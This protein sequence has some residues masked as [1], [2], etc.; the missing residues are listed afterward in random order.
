MTLL[1]PV[2]EAFEAASTAT[3]QTARLVLRPPALEDAPALA[4]LTNDRRIAEMTTRVPYPYT[5]ADAEEF[6]A[7][8]HLDR[9]RVFLITARDGTM[10][11]VCSIACRT[12]T[13]PEIGYWLGVP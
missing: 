9:E 4:R 3:L 2:A 11:G 6:L 10:L 5:L 13:P 7:S 8:Y 12:G 1:E